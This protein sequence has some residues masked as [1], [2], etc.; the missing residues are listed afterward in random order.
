[1]RRKNK[2][3]QLFALSMSVI[4]A[5]NM[6]EAL[7]AM[8]VDEPETYQV[9]NVSGGGTGI[10]EKQMDVSSVLSL[11]E[12]E[13]IA[14]D[15]DAMQEQESPKFETVATGSDAVQKEEYPAFEKSKMAGDIRITVSAPEG[16]FPKGAV[17]QVSQVTESQE[18]EKL[19][20]AVWKELKKEGDTRNLQKVLAFDIMIRDKK[21]QELQP[22]SHAGEVTVS[23]A[24]V[25]MRAVKEGETQL[26]VFH[27]DERLE[28]AQ[29][30]DC[31]V[32]EEAQTI[33][34][35]A[36]NFSVYAVS[37]L[38]NRTKASHM[39]SRPEDGVTAG[40]PF[41]KG[42]G[43]STSFRIP[44]MITLADGTIVAAADARWNTT[45][46]GGGLD[47]IV[48]RSTDGGISWN[49]TFA[50]YLGDN[51]NSYNGTRSTT[52]IDPALATDG[53]KIYMLCDLY[54]YGVALNGNK[55]IAPKAVT[56]FNEDGK[57]RLKKHNAEDSDDSYQFY[58]DGDTIYAEDGNAVPGYVV[59]E[60][61][62]I[63]GNG[64]DSNL[65]FHDSPYQVMRTSYFYLTTSDDGGENWS[66]PQ[67]LNVKT[68]EELAYLAA[69][70]RGIVTED[71]TIVFAA[72]SYKGSEATQRMDFIYSEDEGENWSRA[73]TG[74]P[75]QWSS[76]SAVVELEDGT[77]RF[78]FR[79]GTSHLCYV[80]YREDGWEKPVQTSL[81]TNSNCQISAV[82]YSRKEKGRQ[83]LLVS[84]PTGPDGQGSNSSTGGPAP[85]GKRLNGKIF[86]GLVNEDNTM[87]WM[88]D[89]H[90]QVNQNNAEFMYS[91]LTELED[92]TIALLYEDHQSGWGAGADKY[93][94]MDFQTYPFK[95]IP[96]RYQIT[97]EQTEGGTIV[98]DVEEGEENT[99]AEITA[100]PL[101]G[102]RLS[103]WLV[104]GEKKEA[105]GTIYEVIL[106]EDVKISAVFEK[107]PPKRYRITLE[108]TEGGTIVCDVEE[109]EENTRAEITAEPSEGYRL[110]HWLVNGERKEAVGTV[111]EVI[112]QEDVKISAVFEKILD[113][114]N[115]E[116]HQQN[117]DDDD[118]DDTVKTPP[119]K[120]QAPSYASKGTWN[121]K[122]ETWSFI[123]E[124]GQPAVSTWICTEWNGT[125]QWYYFDQEGRM[126]D[127]WINI[128][129]QTFYLVPESDGTRG[130]MVTGWKSIDGV[131]YY[132]NMDSDGTKGI[133]LKNTVTPDG[134]SVD[135][136]GRWV[137][138]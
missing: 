65:F 39:A 81:L 136:E 135:E 83:V 26:E 127:G 51:G 100:E 69:P 37:Y 59:D 29:K 15:S 8:I 123:M 34:V 32:N 75:D 11:P 106:Q 14:T 122:G 58:L 62:N 35:Q 53:D 49:Y 21:G 68:D 95:V 126:A 90:I 72:Y 17:L 84:C 27:M 55:D 94:T 103:Y 41:P 31:T 44:A 118:D 86:V 52:F 33:E 43:G 116:H 70:G 57:L 78:F 71:G 137:Q 79:N 109:G 60:Y 36:E 107:I 9:V 50:N 63:T 2:W 3:K 7:A 46:D 54:P 22:D 47:T 138:P 128:D 91:C 6:S 64:T 97:L 30:L 134:F 124:D 104:N 66:A 80:D 92:G 113:G 40:H 56:G 77:L 82:R 111:Y 110:S 88:E 114:G 12:F 132:F 19:Q 4:L 13:R 67:L 133:L 119:Q 74:T 112:L 76:E 115:E 130:Q 98:C 101:E 102:Y 16:V 87:E 42:T 61:F 45:Y 1:M 117:S 125:Y 129:G 120:V 38:G 96:Q 5:G 108:Q 73:E 24:K 99:K 93:Y 121:Q 20:T 18:K 25:D 85:D 89:K 28:E 23:F 131:W 10:A 105:A 48:S